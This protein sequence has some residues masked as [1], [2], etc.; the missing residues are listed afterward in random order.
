MHE[1]QSIPY[2]RRLITIE[3]TEGQCE[4]IDPVLV[5]TAN[6]EDVYE[7]IGECW[8]EVDDSKE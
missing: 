1:E 4:E 3:L 2:G 8:I 7:E 6:G 5:G